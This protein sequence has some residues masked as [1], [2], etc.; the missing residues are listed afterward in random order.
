MAKTAWGCAALSVLFWGTAVGQEIVGR[1]EGTEKLTLSSC[2]SFDG[3]RT[4]PWSIEFAEPQGADYKVK[5][6]AAGGGDFSGTG[7]FTGVEASAEINGINGAGKPWKMSML[8]KLE[9]NKLVV[10]LTGD[11]IGVGCKLAS[12]VEAFRVR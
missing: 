4:G 5:G 9:S 2:G 3:I 8:G 6:R 12:E 11:V 7:R 10:A 1:F